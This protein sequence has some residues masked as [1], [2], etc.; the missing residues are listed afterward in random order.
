MADALGR[1]FFNIAGMTCY[2]YD[3]PVKRCVEYVDPP[4]NHLPPWILSATQINT[5]PRRPRC[6]SYE[7]DFTKPKAWQFFETFYEETNQRSEEPRY[8]ERRRRRGQKMPIMQK[9]MLDLFLRIVDPN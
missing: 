3:H 4:K 2:Q 9:V 8:R 5:D 6:K 1:I 7:L